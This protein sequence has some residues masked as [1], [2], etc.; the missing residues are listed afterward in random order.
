[1]NSYVYIFLDPRKE[2]I[3]YYKNIVFF[4]QPFYVGEGIN[5]RIKCHFTPKAL[6]KNC[7]KSNII[8]KILEEGLEP[9]KKILFSGISKNEALEIE[10]DIIK[11]FGTRY[12]KTGILSNV[13]KFGN[14]F[15]K[16]M[17]ISE[18][19]ADN[20]AAIKKAAEIKKGR[21]NI[22]L[23]GEKMAAIIGNKISKVLSEK[24]KNK[25]IIGYWQ[26][27]E[28]AKE[29]KDKLSK[30]LQGNK[31]RLGKLHSV[32]DREKM[33]QKISETKG[34]PVKVIKNNGQIEYYCSVNKAA[35]TYLVSAQMLDEAFKNKKFCNSKKAN[36]RFEII[37]KEEYNQQLKKCL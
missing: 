8:N 18:Y 21:T 15:T 4:Y 31:R 24:Y 23:Y 34:T 36:C 35:K 29:H 20:K 7:L 12:H 3:W 27:K 37:T 11:T 1:M 25:E 6:S 5:N 17:Y 10:S 28:M 2:G 32:K 33:S 14:K 16:E 22:E 9:I 26:G 19:K 30:A 13:F